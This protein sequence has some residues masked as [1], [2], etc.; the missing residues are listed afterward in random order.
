MAEYHDEHADYVS[1]EEEYEEE[2]ADL[3]DAAEGVNEFSEEEGLVDDEI[4]EEDDDEDDEAAEQGGGGGGGGAGGAPGAGGQGQMLYIPGLGYI[5][6]ANFP[7][8]GGMRGGGPA[9]APQQPEGERE[10]ESLS[11]FPAATQ[12]GLLNAMQALREDGRTELTLLVLGKGGVG[13][14]STINSLLNERC[15]NVTAFQQDTATQPTDYSRVAQGFTLRCID[16]PS[17]LDQDNV[18]DAKLEAIAKSIR[19]HQV[20]AVLYLDR[21]DSWKVD[22]LDR[23]VLE[24]VTRVLGPDI[25]ANAVLGFTRASESSAPAGVDFAAHVQARAVALRSA[26][27]KAGGP[28]DAELAVALI[29]NSSRCPTNED[30][31]KVVPPAGTPWI[32]DLVEKVAEVALNVEP[33]QYNAKAAAKA[34]NPNR[35]RKW[36]IPLVLAAQIGL[37]LLLDRVLDE[38]GCRGDANGPFD[39]QTVRERREELKREKE[40]RKR[41]QERKKALASGTSAAATTFYDDFTEEEDEDDF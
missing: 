26:I 12:E 28:A 10:W 30:G 7:G 34:S 40:E 8:L 14:S 9:A 37:K 39:E 5:P 18:S 13:K 21:L 17:L 29:E 27:H 38:D 33:F 31:E 36:L 24:G 41:K 23:K 19:E 6:L 16:T 3:L 4:D 35:R 2:D 15:A 11:D 20:D 32:V 25:W 22:T 1:G